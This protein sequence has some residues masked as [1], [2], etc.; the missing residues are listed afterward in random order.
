[1][2]KKIIV[3]A[4]NSYTIRRIV[5]LSFSEEQEIQLV[6]FE[7]SHQLREKMLELRPHIVLV[8]IKLPEFSGYEVCKFVQE[9]APL[10]HTKVFLLK[11]GFEPIDEA[12]LQNLQYVD[13]ITKPFDSNALVNNIKKILAESPA[14]ATAGAV[15][16]QPAPPPA[17]PA[18]PQAPPV[19]ATP[20]VQPPQAAPAPPPAP[21]Q[22]QQPP[23]APPAP[24]APQMP[25]TPAPPTMDGPLEFPSS[26]PEDLPEI[27]PIQDSDQE[28]NFSDI[29][30]EIDSSNMM[31]E[32]FS[33]PPSAY[34]DDEILPSE[35][36]TQGSQPEKD[37]L[38]SPP[39]EEFDN[40]FKDELDMSPSSLTEEEL[41][42]KR[43]IALQEQELQIGSLTVEE[44]NIKQDIQRM[45][46]QRGAPVQSDDA[47]PVSEPP[48]PSA[49]PDTS[50]M[51]S[52]GSLDEPPPGFDSP[53]DVPDM[54]MDEPEPAPTPQIS[55]LD[56]GAVEEQLFAD[57]PDLPEVDMPE[58]DY[59]QHDH[60]SNLESDTFTTQKL[61]MVEPDPQINM[62]DYLGAQPSAPAKSEEEQ[63]DI[64][65]PMP[66]IDDFPDDF[67]Q[68]DHAPNLEDLPGVDSL[69]QPLPDT[70]EETFV[71][72][73]AAIN[74][75]QFAPPAPTPPEDTDPEPEIPEPP[76]PAPAPVPEPEVEAAA[77]AAIP[78]PEIPEPESVTPQ[79]MELQAVPVPEPVEIPEPQPA[80]QM[81][82]PDLSAQSAEP[83][84]PARPTAGIPNEEILRNLEDKLTHSIKELL[85]EIVPPLAEKIIKEEIEALKLEAERSIN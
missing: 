10:S 27:D 23:Q 13:I 1:M 8:D 47:D 63:F 43:N 54:D 46:Q 7:N 57:E 34:P 67:T 84:E 59:E 39:P 35:E 12:L 28:I 41:N 52:K 17:A 68:P 62:D 16:S 38:F 29:K 80:A 65:S 42:I 20:P 56:M 45:M 5:E 76:A 40:P 55:S 6:S 44:M 66:E 58:V 81:P 4:D 69:T 73:V 71:T 25:P 75:Q 21:P 64:P 50:E 49:D 79:P 60:T 74:P 36:I 19:S 33:M 15:Q 32:D 72:P 83:S 2:S 77:E 53:P 18:P 26:L 11:G 9:S 24:Q 48:Q 61:E 37:N 78:E 3:L 22:M 85:W 51:F 70:L 82:E 14:P 31:D 30:D